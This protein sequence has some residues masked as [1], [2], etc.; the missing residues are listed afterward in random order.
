[1]PTPLPHLA[2]GYQVHPFVAWWR[3]PRARGHAYIVKLVSRPSAGWVEVQIANQPAN[4]GTPLIGE[5]FRA[6]VRDL[7]PVQV[8]P[9]SR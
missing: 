8:G 4:A 2:F 9:R 7:C 6:R 1:M 3:D 5:T